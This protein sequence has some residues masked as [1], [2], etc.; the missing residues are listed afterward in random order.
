MVSPE[1]SQRKNKVKLEPLE[2]TGTKQQ[3]AE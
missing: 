3:T 1:N 2:I